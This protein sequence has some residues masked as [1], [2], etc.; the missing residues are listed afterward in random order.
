VGYV[1]VVVLCALLYRVYY[2]IT[3]F[4]VFLTVLNGAEV[5]RIVVTNSKGEQREPN[6]NGNDGG[7]E[8]DCQANGSN[9]PGS[10]N[11]PADESDDGDKDDKSRDKKPVSKDAKE[12][13]SQA[14]DGS[15]AADGSKT[16]D[17]SQTTDQSK[18]ANRMHCWS[19]IQQLQCP[20]C[21]RRCISIS[22]TGPN[23]APAGRR[24]NRIKRLTR[25]PY[26]R[27]L[28]LKT[29]GAQSG[30]SV[31]TPELNGRGSGKGTRTTTKVRIRVRNKSNDCWNIHNPGFSG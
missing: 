6:D 9:G 31:T 30:T 14:E 4:S 28:F 21:R 12:D 16:K 27:R 19:R 1:E 10:S 11:S 18:A 15:K 7:G 26:G 5:P 2:A 25:E 23:P 8:G 13:E 20:T 3:A 24:P 22:S 29:T 17:E